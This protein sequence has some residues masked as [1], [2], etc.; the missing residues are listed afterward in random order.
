[1]LRAEINVAWPH[2]IE[3]E[4]GEKGKPLVLSYL[5][6]YE[7]NEDVLGP[8]F[9]T[10]YHIFKLID[11]SG[12]EESERC[13]YA[14][15]A[16]ATLGTDILYL[17]ALNCLSFREEEF[18]PLVKRFRLLKHVKRGEGTEISHDELIAIWFYNWLEL[19]A[20][21]SDNNPA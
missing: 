17:L 21:P 15:I 14:N 9:R 2:I 10:M 6:L 20:S 1:M 18:F 5:E 8:Y 13:I 4:L 11:K 19:Q 3:L 7:A 16:R 12:L